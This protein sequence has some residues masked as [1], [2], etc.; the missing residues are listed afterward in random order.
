MG[1]IAEQLIENE[2]FGNDD[3]SIHAPYVKTN[4]PLSIVQVYVHNGTG[5]IEIIKEQHNLPY[6]NKT[7]AKW[8]FNDMMPKHKDKLANKQYKLI[9]KN[10]YIR[11]KFKFWVCNYFTNNKYINQKDK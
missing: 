5:F 4:Q 6:K 8:F 11:K 1:D 9:G 2:M 10:T 3:E 7:L